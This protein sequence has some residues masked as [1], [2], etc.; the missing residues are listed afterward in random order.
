MQEYQSHRGRTRDQPPRKP[1]ATMQATGEPAGHAVRSHC[2]R[3][4]HTSALYL[5]SN[6]PLLFLP[7]HLQGGALPDAAEHRCT[8]GG[9]KLRGHPVSAPAH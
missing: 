9:G 2:S 5:L 8:V 4:V 1:G 7:G 6:G 3:W